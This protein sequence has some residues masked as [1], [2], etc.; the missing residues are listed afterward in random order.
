MDE[1]SIQ[2]FYDRYSYPEPIQEIPPEF[3]DGTIRLEGCPSGFFHLYWPCR[4]FRS[5]LD[6]LVAGCGTSQ[7]ALLAAASPR[8]RFVAVD[9]SAKSLEHSRRLCAKHGITN[10]E[11]RLMPVEQVERLK[12][13]F[14]LIISTGVL[15]VTQEPETALRALRG[16]LRPEGSLF[17]I[18]SAKYSR[19]AVHYVQELLRRAGINADTAE[20]HD[21]EA[22]R[23]LVRSL[24]AEHPLAARFASIQR[25]LASRS[26]TANLLLNPR[27][28]AY[29]VPEVY[30]LLERAGCVLQEWLNRSRYEPAYL[31]LGN[32]PWMARI[33]QLPVGERYAIGELYTMRVHQHQFIACRSDRPK[34]SY[35]LSVNGI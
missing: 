8:S 12:S 14:D 16:V 15:V 20:D 1:D 10:V 4:E 27:D 11:H 3:F 28:R 25:E 9:V 13:T 5:D 19:I 33:G 17:L 34:A 24:P 30:E 22:A 7:A 26:G 2:A 6:V 23:D 32:S 21:I 29:S 31:G 18:V 35:G